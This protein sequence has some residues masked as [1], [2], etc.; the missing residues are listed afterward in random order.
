MVELQNS[1]TIE[2]RRGSVSIRTTKPV[3]IPGRKASVLAWKE[4]IPAVHL[5]IKTP[6]VQVG[7]EITLDFTPKEFLIE[8]NS[9]SLRNKLAARIKLGELYIRVGRYK[10]AQEAWLG[11]VR[12]Q[13]ENYRFHRGL[14]LS[15][16]ELDIVKA[17]KLLLSLKR[18]EMPS[19]YIVLS[20][21][22]KEILINLYTKTLESS[23]TTK[24]ILLH[25]LSGE[26]F[27]SHYEEHLKKY[28]ADGVPPLYQ[29]VC[30]L[31]KT[32]GTD[33][34]DG[35]YYKVVKDTIEFSAHP[36]VQSTL[37]ILN[38]YISNLQQHSSFTTCAT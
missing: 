6:P 9:V 17:S 23:A 2:N 37:D 34:V 26:A 3:Y 36:L 7:E 1:T 19:S 14:Q 28:I 25:L 10:E 18:L 11:L 33:A 5:A 38:K 4:N 21:P 31:V 16:L 8:M 30:G 20:E 22:Q 15:F 13:P 12:E 32:A 35:E 24:R 29:D 27:T